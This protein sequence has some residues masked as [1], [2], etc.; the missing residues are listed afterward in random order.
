MRWSEMNSKDRNRLRR[1]LRCGTYVC[2]V[3]HEKGEGLAWRGLVAK[4]GVGFG[5][6]CRTHQRILLS[7]DII[8]AKQ[9][10]TV[11]TTS[12]VNQNSLI[13]KRALPTPTDQ[14]LR[15][16]LLVF[17]SKYLPKC[18]HEIS[19]KLHIVKEII[20]PLPPIYLT[21]TPY[22]SLMICNVTQ[23]RNSARLTFQVAI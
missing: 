9:C 21:P 18:N 12:P 8:R 1:L 20:S 22:L 2:W 15:A 17:H 13:W 3:K 11:G 19:N 6:F 10:M 16:W 14:L 4:E 5:V 7:N 23:C